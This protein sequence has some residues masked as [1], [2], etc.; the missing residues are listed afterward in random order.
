MKEHVYGTIGLSEKD[1]AEG[2]VVFETWEPNARYAWD[3][4][5]AIGHYL[6]ELQAGRLVGR[7]CTTCG[8][9]M[10]PPRMFCEQCF[11]PTDSWVTLQDTGTV[12]T[13][14]LCNV[15]WNMERVEKPLMPAVIAIDG[16]S[17]GMGILHLLGEVE[18]DQVKIGMRVRAVWKPAA[19]R[20]GAITDIAYFKPL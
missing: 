13:F 17:P 18:P 6:K 11:V 5:V 8:R 15:T 10:I 16:A 3:T 12:T 9:T 7:Y 2:R 1:F 14:S 20:V 19:E 4:G